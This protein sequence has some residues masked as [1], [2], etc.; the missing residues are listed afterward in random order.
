MDSGSEVTVGDTSLAADPADIVDGPF[1]VALTTWVVT[2]QCDYQSEG[3]EKRTSLN[4][5]QVL[6]N[7]D[8]LQPCS[9]YIIRCRKVP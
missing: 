7:T 4:F 2:I 1:F 3:C 9:Q 8:R 5:K 6:L